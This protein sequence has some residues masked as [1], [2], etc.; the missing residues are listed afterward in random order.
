MQ[1]VQNPGRVK[2]N[3]AS[4]SS[5]TSCVGSSP[6]F[7][8]R[9]GKLG[10]IALDELVTPA[11]RFLSLFTRRRFRILPAAVSTKPIP[12]DRSLEVN[13]V[14]VERPVARA[15]A[16][17]HELITRPSSAPPPQMSHGGSSKLP[18]RLGKHARSSARV[19][20]GL[21]CSKQT[22]HSARA[23]RAPGVAGA[24]HSSHVHEAHTSCGGDIAAVFAFARRLLLQRSIDGL[25]TLYGHMLPILHP[26]TSCVGSAPPL[27]LRLLTACA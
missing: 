9:D 12:L 5:R 8:L 17:H 26:H 15:V 3:V 19:G 22:R 10:V 21:S 2:R 13:A 14:R 18:V 6:P 24:P 23:P 4:R 1:A 25:Y 20:S 16:E 11:I 7:A 27:A